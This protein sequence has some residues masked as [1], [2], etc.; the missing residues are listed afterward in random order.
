MRNSDRPK[1][2]SKS[3]ALSFELF[4]EIGIVAQLARSQLSDQLPEGLISSHFGILNHL[5]RVADGRMPIDLANA[6]QVAKTTMTHTLRGLE[7]HKLIT[8]KPCPDDGRCKRVWITDAGCKLREQ[9][10]AN[11]GP[12]LA[13]LLADIPEQQIQ[14]MIETLTN[15]RQ[16][17]DANRNG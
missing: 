10:I 14:S 12:E 8:R 4:N 2:A 6:F 9:T 3:L 1:P 13:D 5:I 17:L 11:V 7:A 15:I 16:Q